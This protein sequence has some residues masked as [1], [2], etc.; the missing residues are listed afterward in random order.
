VKLSLVVPCYNEAM[1]LPALIARCASLA[2][3]PRVEIV[4][5]DNGST[6]NTAEVLPGLLDRHPGLRSVRVAV[7]QGYGFGVMSGLRAAEG[8]ILGWTHADQQTDPMDAKAGLEMFA[9]AADPS[10]L[11]VKGLRHGRPLAD[12]FF[13]AGMTAFETLLTGRA[14]RDINAQPTMFHRSFFERWD[15]APN[16]F[17]LDLYAYWLAKDAGLEIRR[18][19]VR[20]G[21]RQFGASH[22]NTG[23]AARVKFIR[24]TISFSLNLKKVRDGRAH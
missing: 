12:S 2:A 14:M 22:W 21:P 1:N 18:F 5:V 16:D 6:D 3:D 7:N 19:P 10:R 24:R 17:A 4:L 13:T 15:D 20:F 9:R 23:M 11:F 8:D